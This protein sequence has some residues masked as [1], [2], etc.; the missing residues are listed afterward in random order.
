MLW[1]MVALLA[2]GVA[3]ALFL[4]WYYQAPSQPGANP[5]PKL[6]AMFNDRLDAALARLTP[7]HAAGL[8]P[9]AADSARAFLS[10]VTELTQHCRYQSHVTVHN[11]VVFDLTLSD[12]SVVKDQYSGGQR[13]PDAQLPGVP[14]LRIRMA[15]GKAVEITSDGSERQAPPTAM[16][17]ALDQIIKHLIGYDQGLRPDAYFAANASPADLRQAWASPA[18]SGSADPRS[19]ASKASAPSRPSPP[20]KP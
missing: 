18:D 7:A 2:G 9:Q 1:P 10:R 16:V 3:V 8:S 12:G 20:L 6:V 11:L 19:A 13:C 14:I 5:N 15:Q 17:P 4:R